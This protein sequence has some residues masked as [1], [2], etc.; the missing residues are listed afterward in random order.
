MS[1]TAKFPSAIATNTDLLL[2][3][4]N[5]TCT[6]NGTI[7]S[8]ATTILT[9][10]QNPQIQTPCV[11]TVDNEKILIG[12]GTSTQLNVAS[13][14]RGFDGTTA[15]SHNN[16]A[17]VNV[18]V[19]AWHHNQ[20]AAE[21]EAIEAFLGVNGGNLGSS[22]IPTGSYDW[23]QTPGGSISPGS[24]SITLTPVPQGISGTVKNTYVYL[25]SG[26]GTAEA[27]LITGG[28]AISGA[29]SGT[30][31]VTAANSHS[32]AWTASSATG[33][34]KEAMNTLP[35]TGGFVLIPRGT[36]TL[37]GTL[38]L[39][40]GTA[41]AQSTVNSIG[42][43]GQGPG[44]AV[45]TA[46]PTTGATTLLWG[47]ATGGTMVKV[48]GPIGNGTLSN[49][50]IDCNGS[51]AIG[52]DVVHSYAW[53]YSMLNIVNYT[54]IGLRAM[55]TD[56]V[57][58]AM[59][60]GC[61]NNYFQDVIVTAGGV[62][63]T[64]GAQFGQGVPNTVSIFDFA[65]NAFMNCILRCDAGIGL[66]L[67][68]ADNNVFT[69][70]SFVG[71]TG[72]KFTSPI[73][74]FPGANVFL[75]CPVGPIAASAGFDLTNTNLNIFLPLSSTD[76]PQ[77]PLGLVKFATGTTFTGEWFG[78]QRNMPLYYAN[79]TSPA[80]ISNTT[81]QVAFTRAYTV[82]ANMLA[83]AG[84]TLRVRVAGRYSCVTGGSNFTIYVRIGGAT[85][86]QV[87]ITATN[88]ANN[89]SWCME[90]EMALVTP[91]AGGSALR[92][93]TL[94][95]LGFGNNN[96]GSFSV[97]TTIANA[98]TPYAQWSVASPGNSI[99]LDTFSVEILYP[100]TIQ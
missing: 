48:A 47:G 79:T 1:N 89:Y 57:F 15:A 49:L 73:A 51:A 87:T 44:R 99:T 16:G 60:N 5:A 93:Y 2:A 62:G 28:T 78:I 31:I 35:S 8:S 21:V 55:A 36:I 66:E 29:A 92:G 68:F 91:G 52:L 22:G 63:G 83:I 85:I 12:S 17:A 64:V 69:M 10:T 95:A 39:G 6:L 96:S 20:T 46:I 42:L 56:F 24:N 100:S 67:R 70:C 11:V 84:T 45:D 50:M 76:T 33:G 77:D 94:G 65:S 14:G 40:D 54:S 86:G 34:I 59:A 41:T 13:G 4:D 30:I 75:Q 25:S 81:S 32:G 19:V 37:R 82:L 74:G 23:S 90:T 97:D 9:S 61:N 88:G 18:N 58:D 38:V 43:S 7:T 80:A 26:T 98:V 53:F 71:T 72:L 3:T 27:V